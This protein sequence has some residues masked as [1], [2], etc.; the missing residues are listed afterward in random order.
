MKANRSICAVA[1]FLLL[2]SGVAHAQSGI[3]SKVQKLEETIRA[4][5]RRVAMLEEQL[6][7]K[8]PQVPVASDKANWRMLKK[9]MSESDVERLLGSPT[10]V[11]AFGSFTVWHY[12]ERSRAEVQFDGD[13]RTVQSWHEP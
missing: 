11:D 7:D 4:L 9:G 3:D 12:G 5:E 8:S 6:R 1:S 13:S 10:R 2:V